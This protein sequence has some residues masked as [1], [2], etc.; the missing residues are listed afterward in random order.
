LRPAATRFLEKLRDAKLGKRLE[1]ALD[2]L[3]VQPRPPLAK[4]L[5][6][7]EDIWRIR[8]GDYRILYQIDD[9]ERWLRIAEIGH[10]REVYRD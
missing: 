3:A 7:K 2:R 5:S 1:D 10:R 4:L 8:V 9:A 6:Q